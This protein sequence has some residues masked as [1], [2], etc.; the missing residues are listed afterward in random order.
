MTVAASQ[1]QRAR[2]EHRMAVNLKSVVQ[3][4]LK[5]AAMVG[6]FSDLKPLKECQRGVL[7]LAP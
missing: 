2:L 7:D 3:F 4:G 5:V 1:R 6:L